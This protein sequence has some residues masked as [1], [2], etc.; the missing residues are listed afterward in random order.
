MTLDRDA[1]NASLAEVYRIHDT[2]FLADKDAKQAQL[3][4]LVDPLEARLKA[5]VTKSSSDQAFV[6]YAKGR[7]INALEDYSRD[8]EKLLAKAIKLD[9]SLVEAW[10][11]LGEVFWKK[12]DLESA[13]NCFEGALKQT[14]GRCVKALRELSMLSRQMGSPQAPL[15]DANGQIIPGSESVTTAAST[16]DNVK[17]SVDLAKKAV[18]LDVRDGTSWY[19]LGT[20]IMT[21]FFQITQDADCL[22]MALSAY[23]KALQNGE[24]E[25]N[26]D[27][28]F[29]L[30]N[31]HAY[32]ERYEEACA[33]WQ[34]AAEIDPALPTADAIARTE[35]HVRKVASMV[36]KRAN[37]KPKRLASV[38]GGL[39]KLNGLGGLG[40]EELGNFRP[41]VALSQLPGWDDAERD[42]AATARQ[43][44]KKRAVNLRALGPGRSDNAPPA[45]WIMAD[46]AGD[47][48]CVSVYH[49]DAKAYDAVSEKKVVTL[50]D[51]V[52]KRVQLG[53]TRYRLISVSDPRNMLVNGRALAG[54][55][56]YAGLSS[57]A[58]DA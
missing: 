20:A 30:G 49:L 8:A 21:R 23:D 10:N 42:A 5:V 6:C 18:A 26:P 19:Y 15:K 58:F 17:R 52:V 36:E 47:C 4:A 25:T 44:A 53:A 12:G 41:L 56:Q 55:F 38:C 32:L 3:K 28:H 40:S 46:E 27:L 50:L 24:G 29:N 57:K 51:P 45:C 48:V 1:V 22:K 13:H 11:S 2:V 33:S 14:D 54:S 43:G 16:V 7:A 34:R 37:L 9:P 39:A 31:L 35:R